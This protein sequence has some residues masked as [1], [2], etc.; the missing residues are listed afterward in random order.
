[1]YTQV[2]YGGALDEIKF[3]TKIEFFIYLKMY[4]ESLIILRPLLY[5]LSKMTS[6]GNLRAFKHFVENTQVVSYTIQ[7]DE[8][9]VVKADGKV[10]K[11]PCSL[12]IE[13]DFMEGFIDYHLSVIDYIYKDI[14]DKLFE[15]CND[16]S[17]SFSYT[18]RPEE[19]KDKDSDVRSIVIA[20]SK[21]YR[22]VE[23]V[24]AM[25]EVDGKIETMEYYFESSEAAR[26]F[27]GIGEKIMFYESY[28]SLMEKINTISIL[29]NKYKTSP[30]V[31]KNN[32]SYSI[33][34]DYNG[35]KCS[36]NVGAEAG[37]EMIMEMIKQYATFL[38]FKE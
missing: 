8:F 27:Q 36:M 26:K 37:A 33:L 18:S 10:Q 21:E 35:E 20:N 28:G 11:F 25:V 17:C 1:M 15:I 13:K 22:R 38:S 23:I 9:C 14:M 7:D 12:D 19:E 2:F 16:K 24:T 32:Y 6:L 5:K 3:Q 4:K 30:E 31:K 34:F 29:S